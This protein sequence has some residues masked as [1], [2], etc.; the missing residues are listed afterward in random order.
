MSISY[1]PTVCNLDNYVMKTKSE[2]YVLLFPI[3][4]TS[5][6]YFFLSRFVLELHFCMCMGL[7]YIFR[8]I[9]SRA[10][11][12]TIALSL[13]LSLAISFS[14]SLSVV[15]GPSERWEGATQAPGSTGHG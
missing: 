4:Y 15:Q 1:R 5:R 2:K 11:S 10:M 7:N 13:S 9:F 3:N 6:M 12:D 8:P 14:G